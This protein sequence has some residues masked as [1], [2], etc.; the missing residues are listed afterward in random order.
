[1]RIFDITKVICGCYFVVMR[2][3]RERGRL[4]ASSVAH[5]NSIPALVYITREQQGR[6]VVCQGV[7]KIK[8]EV[9]LPEPFLIIRV[10]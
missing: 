6:I 7:V 1:M 4:C 9:L 10:I 3:R 5:F 2:G 8:R